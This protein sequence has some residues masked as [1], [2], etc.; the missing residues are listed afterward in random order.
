MSLCTLDTQDTYVQDCCLFVLRSHLSVY[1]YTHTFMCSGSLA[2]G[3]AHRW[4]IS[5]Q[6]EHVS[7]IFRTQGRPHL[8]MQGSHVP[9]SPNI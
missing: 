3:I 1:T 7:S 2:S 9:R 8:V 4:V 5:L 6:L